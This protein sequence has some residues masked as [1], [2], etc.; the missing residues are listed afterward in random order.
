MGGCSKNAALR[1][2]EATRVR[3]PVAVTHLGIWLRRCRASDRTAHNSTC[4]APR[5]LRSSLWL[6]WMTFAPSPSECNS[7]F[8]GREEGGG[9]G[10][11]C[12]RTR[13]SGWC[14]AYVGGGVLSVLC[15]GSGL[16]GG[17][18]C[19]VCRSCIVV[20]CSHRNPSDYRALRPHCLHAGAAAC[21][22]T[23]RPAVVCCTG[24]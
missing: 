1:A 15:G 14:C 12:G 20:L 22:R 18:L 7:I 5:S 9:C 3:A 21:V 17:S 10:G 11:G 6:R 19:C 4:R 16:C 23:L 13:T 8:P 2:T 24:I